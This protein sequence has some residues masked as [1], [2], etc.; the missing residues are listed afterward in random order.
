MVKNMKKILILSTVL[1]ALNACQPF[2]DDW[3]W[4]VVKPM[5]GGKGFPDAST[6]YGRGFKEGCANG[7]ISSARGAMSTFLP[8]KLSTNLIATNPDFSAG[9]WDGHEQCVYVNDH[10]VV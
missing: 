6:D 5:S 8:R 2:P 1:F 3:D 7:L 4:S 9:W 10:D